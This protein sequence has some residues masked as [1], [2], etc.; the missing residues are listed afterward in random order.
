MFCDDLS[1]C[2]I[3]YFCKVSYL[4]LEHKV[5]KFLRK[6]LLLNESDRIL[7]A[8]SAGLDS[9]VLLH[10]L[11][12]LHYTVSVAHCNF[13]LRGEESDGDDF[14][15]EEACKRLN[16]PLFSKRFETENYALD[17]K[18]SIQMAAREL[19]YAWFSQL[20]NSHGFDRVAT[21]HHAGDQS[22]TVLL[23]LISGKGPESLRGIPA[24]NLFLIRPLLHCSKAELEEYAIEKHIHWRNDSSNEHSDYQR[25]FIRHEIIPRL[26][27]IN[28]S[29][30]KTLDNIAVRSEE[31]NLLAR[32]AIAS[33]L[34]NSLEETAGGWRLHLQRI[35]D[36]PAAATLLWKALSPFDFEGIIIEDILS[37]VSLSG[38][39]F[40]SATHLLTVDRGTL[41]IEKKQP[42]QANESIH[43]D[44]NTTSIPLGEKL[45]LLQK[46][47]MKN[48]GITF[49][50]NPFEALIDA[51]KLT[52]PLKIRNWQEGDF[53]FPLGMHHPKKLS[54]YFI[55]KK[56]PL[57]EKHRKLLLFNGDELVWIIGDRIDQRYRITENTRQI[58]HL[59]LSL[60]EHSTTF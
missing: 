21:A 17:K 1:L 38:K 13:G 50:K 22:E 36:H 53:F 41:F 5:L 45:L 3:G 39:E 6:D 14:F 35:T 19:R 27:S 16:I 57:P 31:W 10:V 18:I 8:V 40:H 42:L 28:P 47:P 59:T 56:V 49:P 33:I 43:I 15:C 32:E 51:D 12:R 52:Y 58:L 44:E 7:V 30:E 4:K 25:N 2:S 20:K 48:E 34:E 46:Y 24:R 37:S 23:N 55:D 54:D 60:H 29:L 9:M 11:H 26:K